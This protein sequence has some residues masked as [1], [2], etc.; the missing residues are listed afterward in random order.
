MRIFLPNRLL[1]MTLLRTASLLLSSAATFGV[2]PV[3][4]RTVL[5]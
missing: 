1:F 4:R 2:I 3:V 5:L